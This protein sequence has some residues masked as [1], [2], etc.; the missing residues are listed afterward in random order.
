MTPIV[1]PGAEPEESTPPSATRADLT[2]EEDGFFSI[3]FSM[4]VT[5]GF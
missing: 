4:F 1:G 3:G 2:G 5:A